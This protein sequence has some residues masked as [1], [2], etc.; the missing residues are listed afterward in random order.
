M[1]SY[2]ALKVLPLICL[3]Q[4]GCAEAWTSQGKLTAI[5]LRLSK[6]YIT[7]WYLSL[8]HWFLVFLFV[9][10]FKSLDI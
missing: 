6:L 3:L 10:V 7:I 8:I 5:M 4:T 2:G 9:F 1:N